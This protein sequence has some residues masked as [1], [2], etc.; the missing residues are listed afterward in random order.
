MQVTATLLDVGASWRISVLQNR[1]A[2]LNERLATSR[3]VISYAQALAHEATLLAAA[4]EARAKKK[5]EAA[6]QGDVAKHK[7][8][9]RRAKAKKKPGAKRLLP[10]ESSDSASTDDSCSSCGEHW[11]D[12]AHSLSLIH[13]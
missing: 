12:I 6:A 8:A 5:K 4:A 9:T 11:R 7:R 1:T 13:I 2:G 3:T 10:A